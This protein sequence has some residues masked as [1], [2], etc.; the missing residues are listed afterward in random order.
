[1]TCKFCGAH[2][3]EGASFCP[4]CSKSQI[5]KIQSPAPR[6]WKR[7]ALRAACLLALVLAAAGLL[8]SVRPGPDPGEAAP[9][10]AAEQPAAETASTAEETQAQ[11]VE[12]ETVVKYTDDR[13][14]YTL[15]LSHT[16]QTPFEEIFEFS[17]NPGE[18]TNV[19]CQLL[20][21]RAGWDAGAEFLEKVRAVTVTA[22]AISGAAMEPGGPAALEA[23]PLGVLTSEVYV[24]ADAE[25]SMVVWTFRMEN[26]DTIL[27]RQALR[28]ITRGAYAYHYDDYAMET[29]GELDALLAQILEE[30]PE[31]AMIK[32]YL[33][34]VT[35]T[36]PHTFA[37]RS[38]QVLGCIDGRGQTVF[39]QTVTFFHEGKAQ[40]DV[41]NV[42][43]Q[44]IGGVGVR[45]EAYVSL[46]H[47][48][49]CGWETGV[50]TADWGSVTLKECT[51]E[52]NGSGVVWNSIGFY[53]E[54]AVNS[55]N[56]FRNNGTAFWFRS[57]PGEGTVFFPGC[58]FAGNGVNIQNDIG[59]PVDLS[60]AAVE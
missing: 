5:E 52:N 55:D 54:D 14:V 20:V 26:G 10:Q 41:Q 48:T 49:L 29:D 27:L 13:G 8:L 9:A 6:P 2:L 25:E 34:E 57:Y 47:C 17:M 58:T 45:A 19:P 53:G 56:Q 11:L 42:V 3:P 23:F 31:D 38:Y 21:T 33:P 36:Q 1:M 43:F 40:N 44:G 24:P 16:G 60:G 28:K 51:V 12:G 22:E 46:Q 7:K 35:Y 32:L 59:Q 18:D 37:G 30:T 4:V 39:Q 50:Q 15:T